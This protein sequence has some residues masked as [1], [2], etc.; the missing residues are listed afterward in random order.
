MFLF[1]EDT[2]F[3]NFIIFHS[4]KKFF[5]IR[6]EPIGSFFLTIQCEFGY[7]LSTFVI[8]LFVLGGHKIFM[9]NGTII[10]LS[11]YFVSLVKHATRSLGE[12]LHCV[13]LD[14]SS[15]CFVGPLF[16]GPVGSPGVP[17]LAMTAVII[18][19]IVA[20]RY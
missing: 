12:W 17:L 3:L 18:F 8:F 10:K 5:F 19:L 16:M 7:F 20:F 6:L 2:Y 9:F 14:C 4:S 11:I 13:V 1:W 15:A